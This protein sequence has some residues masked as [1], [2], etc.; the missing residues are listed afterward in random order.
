MKLKVLHEWNSRKYLLTFTW[1][2]FLFCGII[3]D[4]LIYKNQFNIV[5]LHCNYLYF[6]PVCHI[7]LVIHVV[8]I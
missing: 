6:I 3:Y 4:Y 8:C 1:K 7:L 2:E 5:M